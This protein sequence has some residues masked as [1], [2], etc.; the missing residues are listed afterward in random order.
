MQPIP[1][2]AQR[3][4]RLFI[5]VD[6]LSFVSTGA[7][8]CTVPTTAAKLTQTLFPQHLEHAATMMAQW[9][10]RRIRTH[11]KRFW[12]TAMS[13]CVYTIPFPA[14]RQTATIQSNRS[15]DESGPL[16]SSSPATPLA[17]WVC[18][19]CGDHSRLS[20]PTTAAGFAA[21][22]FFLV[23]HLHSGSFLAGA[24]LNKCLV[25]SLSHRPLTFLTA[26]ALHF[27]PPLGTGT[28]VPFPPPTLQY[29]RKS[30]WRYPSFNLAWS[31]STILLSHSSPLHPTQSLSLSLSI[32]STSPTTILFSS[33][34]TLSFFV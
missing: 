34:S 5:I 21:S 14:K 12:G 23:S 17:P 27:S 26:I 31:S 2:E 28:K 9:L 6:W 4:K 11:T 3:P 25:G 19:P 33:Y 15:G 24:V 18:V 7:L 30:R 20:Q 22:P 1:L 29:K 32:F 8:C 10:L 13:L 16:S